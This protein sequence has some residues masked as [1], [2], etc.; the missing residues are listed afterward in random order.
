M[1]NF[2]N[3]IVPLEGSEAARAMQAV[4][5]ITTDGLDFSDSWLEAN[6]PTVVPCESSEHFRR[7]IIPRLSLALEGQE[8]FAVVTDPIENHPRAFRV[9]S[10]VGALTEL[11]RIMGPFAFVIFNRDQTLAILC[12]KLNYYLVAGSECFVSTIVGSPLAQSQLVFWR[13][14]QGWSDRDLERH[15]RAIAYRYLPRSMTN[16]SVLPQGNR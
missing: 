11:D 12:T 6:S 14:A 2:G 1:V 7:E 13:F 15:L 10:S 5:A 4:T 3:I 9:D 8:W 16:L